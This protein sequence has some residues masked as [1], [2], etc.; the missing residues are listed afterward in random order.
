MIIR[1]L[2]LAPCAAAFMT[3]MCLPASAMVTHECV[4]GM[5]TAQSYTRNFK[6]EANGIIRDIR[7]T[8]RQALTDANELQSF[9]DHTDLSWQVQG[10][11]RDAVK[12]DVNT[13]ESRMCRLEAIRRAVAPWQRAE[14]DRIATTARLMADNTEAAIN[15]G[16]AHW[17]DLVSA[18]YRKY[19]NNLYDE[20]QNL[21][22][23]TDQ[24]FAYTY[25]SKE[26]RNLQPLP[27]TIYRVPVKPG[28]PILIELQ[29]RI[30]K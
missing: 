16:N 18:K 11:K 3:L 2:L 12:D 19:A 4:A 28:E 5:P 14:I 13:L 10:L 27:Q 6:N 17:D 1:G 7:D 24:A 23:S 22:R 8:A 20:A 15:F 26:Y 29:L 30:Q 9:A 21:A 25:V